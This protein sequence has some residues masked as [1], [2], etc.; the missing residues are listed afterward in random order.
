MK[1]RSMLGLSLLPALAAVPSGA[2]FAQ[3]PGGR[4]IRM[5]VGFAAGGP[6]DVVARLFAQQLTEVLGQPV[7][8]ENRPGAG[9]NI[10]S[11]EAARAP[12][13]GM[14][15]LYNTAG[16]VIAPAL[17][18]KLSFHPIRD[19]AP[20]ALTTTTYLAIL[21]NPAVPARDA[22][23][24]IAY[25]KA[26]PNKVNF[27]VG[28][29]GTTP[30]LAMAHLAL[31]NDLKV[32]YVPYKGAAP[33]MA[34]VVAGHVQM[35]IE[36][37]NTMMPFVRD[38]RVRALAL[39]GPRRSAIAPDLPTYQESMGSPF[40]ASSWQGMVVPAATPKDVIAR[41]NAAVNKVLQDPALSQR[42][43]A[44]GTEVLGGSSERYG[45]FLQSEL[46]RWDKVVKDAGIKTS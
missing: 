10:A 15:I 12:A 1:R 19:F 24:L 43:A 20:V 37:V 33:A 5:L 11:A 36:P 30:H 45:A 18:E 16:L 46:L 21:V 26:N 44:S 32:N 27:A 29:L 6:T 25:I 9:S 3:M 7:I 2:L 8:V 13:D 38:N 42:L 23:S 22:K 41:L 40:E 14:T 17:G 31:Q 39:L 34:D 4:A 28:G 35:T